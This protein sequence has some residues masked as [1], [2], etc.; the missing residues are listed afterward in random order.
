MNF[1]IEAAFGRDLRRKKCKGLNPARPNYSITCS[2]WRTT[3]TS[4]AGTKTA[5]SVTA[6]SRSAVTNAV[7]GTARF[8]CEET[9]HKIGQASN[10]LLK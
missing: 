4:L 3:V 8:G 7:T 10:A 1:N 9:T 5:T 2:G 6:G